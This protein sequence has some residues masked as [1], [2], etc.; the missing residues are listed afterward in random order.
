VT[1][2][3]SASFLAQNPGSPTTITHTATLENCGD[4]TATFTTPIEYQ[5]ASVVTVALPGSIASARATTPRGR[6]NGGDGHAFS[7]E[8][9]PFPPVEVLTVSPD[10][11]LIPRGS[12]FRVT[13]NQSVFVPEVSL[14]DPTQ[15]QVFLAEVTDTAQPPNINDAVELT[16]EN[17]A[18]G[19]VFNFRPAAL[20]EEGKR[21]GLVIR[22]GPD[23]VRGS[24]GGS[25]MIADVTKLYLVI[26]GGLFISTDPIDGEDGVP[27]TDR[28]CAVFVRDL[29]LSAAGVVTD[30]DDLAF[31]EA[32][33]T[34]SATNALGG[35]TSVPVTYSVDGVDPVSG[36]PDP[37]AG[38]TSNRVCLTALPNIYPC[39]DV[40][41]LLPHSSD[42]TLR[43]D[44]VD[45]PDAE[46]IDVVDEAIT[47]TTGGLPQ[48]IDTFYETIPEANLVGALTTEVP[49]NGTLV[50]VFDEDIDASTV[51]A[52][53]L[54]LA[55]GA[56]LAATATAQGSSLRVQ[57]DALMAFLT[58]HELTVDGGVSAL[59]FSDGRYLGEDLRAAFTTSPAN[60]AR[61]SPIQGENAMETTVTPIVFT[62]PMFQPSLNTDT[63]TAF[64]D[65]DNVVVEG[66]VAVTLDDRFSGLFSPL[67]TYREGNQVRLTVGTGVL[68]FLGNPLPA[69]VQVTWASI[70][71]APAAAARVP[72]TIGAAAVAPNTGAVTATQE[73]LLTL[74]TNNVQQL[75]NRMLPQSFNP[76]S[77]RL[78][79][80]GSCGAVGSHVIETRQRF[81]ITT[82]VGGSDQIGVNPSEVLRAACSYRLT[83]RQSL[84]ANIHTIAN[85]GAA[86]VVIN[87]TGE[88]TAPTVLSSNIADA[89]GGDDFVAIFS[90][91][92]D[93]VTV[94]AATVTVIDVTNGNLAVDG[95][96]TVDGATVRF[97]PATFWRTGRVYSVVFGAEVRDLAG[98][99]LVPVAR[100]LQTETTPPSAPNTA[101]VEDDAL[102]L[103]F[104][105]R[106]DPASV[107]PTTFGAIA[108][109]GTVLVQ[110][111]AGETVAACVGVDG[112]RIV[113]SHIDAA[114]GTALQLIVTTSVTDE[115]GNA[116]AAQETISA[117]AP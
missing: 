1:E 50:L 100:T 13:F 40:D 53:G 24:V 111:A 65:T 87:V 63:I 56:P 117:T 104:D 35:E 37:A 7:F 8:I 16:C 32:S 103:S 79:Q 85:T 21:Y 33:I 51:D 59:R 58:Q 86:D 4:A 96:F 47:F 20:L 67:P 82:T 68:D 17:C 78:E 93:P 15:T 108:A 91:P 28:V 90:E 54:A 92:I 12:E 80:V 72:D 99:A 25:I 5:L 74:N 102:V 101:T 45:Q 31:L 66:A 98:N 23:G 3:L 76:T 22:G 41:E 60:T 84:F 26:G 73:F 83:L 18:T 114:P 36:Q 81:L 34:L 39:R 107:Q 109:A 112:A 115:A 61:I 48:L 11:G 113:V 9:I 105:E 44:F 106:L 27:V 70:L 19:E 57:G 62:R 6:L 49:V 52:A 38:T 2:T 116:V 14:A 94:S 46:T 30:A 64:D 43:L 75:K 77:V 42:I 55:S 97:T 69:G 95:A 71:S 88:T 110:T 10:G 89:A 29:D